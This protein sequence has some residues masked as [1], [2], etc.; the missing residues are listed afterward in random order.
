[1]ILRDF[2]C[3]NV[4]C[5]FVFERLVD[6]DETYF[7]CVKCG[8]I[9]TKIITFRGLVKVGGTSTQ[10]VEPKERQHTEIREFTKD[11]KRRISAKLPEPTVRSDV[12]R[13]LRLDVKREV[14][15]KRN[16]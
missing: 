8:C 15:R 11:G 4:S 14:E 12:S 6:R 1:M 5:R 2:R 7:T 3:I 10:S 9:G 13:N 16:R